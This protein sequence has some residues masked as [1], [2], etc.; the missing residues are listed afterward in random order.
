MEWVT[1]GNK[2]MGKNRMVGM[3]LRSIA[4]YLTKLEDSPEE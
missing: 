2:I 1:T 3:V 4:D